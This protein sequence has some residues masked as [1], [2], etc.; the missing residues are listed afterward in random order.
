MLWNMIMI[1]EGTPC[2]CVSKGSIENYGHVEVLPLALSHGVA[3]KPFPDT[4][5]ELKAY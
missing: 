5:R 4:F 2:L 3:V 1:S